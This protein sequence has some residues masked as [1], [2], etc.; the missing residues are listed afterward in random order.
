MCEARPHRGPSPGDKQVLN[1]LLQSPKKD[2]YYLRAATQD[3]ARVTPDCLLQAG[4]DGRQGPPLP[5]PSVLW[6]PY[7][8][9]SQPFPHSGLSSHHLGAMTPAWKLVRAGTGS[10]MGSH[11]CLAQSRLSGYFCGPDTAES[12]T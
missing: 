1:L 3:E 6:M 5:G 4:G 2:N 10:D 11:M 8:W 9:L 12:N 7:S